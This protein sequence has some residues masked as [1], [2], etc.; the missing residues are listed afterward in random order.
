MSSKYLKKYIFVLLN[1]FSLIAFASAIEPLR[2]ANRMRKD[3][4]FMWETIGITSGNVTCSNGTVVNCK[5]SLGITTHR[6]DTIV[7]C[8]GTNIQKNST[9]PLL[10]WLRREYRKGLNIGGLCTA[11]QILADAGLLKGKKCTIHWENRDS[12]LE[13][14]PDHSLTSS[15][16]VVDGNVFSS[17]GGTASADLMLHLIGKEFG[18]DLA[19]SVADQMIHTSIRTEKDDQRLS[20]PTRIGIRN[21]KLSTVLELMQEALE[22]PYTPS[23]LAV[24]VGIS[25]RQLERLFRRY[26]KRSPKRYYMELRLQK[27]RNLLLQTNMTVINVALACGFSSPSHFSKCYRDYF[28]HTP[29]RERGSADKI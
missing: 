9:K 23:E 19:N 6:D 3:T 1:D 20:I 7:I 18:A 29:Y 13:N 24:E 17:A 12:F 27:S 26:L 28:S 10:S 22:E 15:I 21:Q 25:T 2:L 5:T 14:F 16:Y 4:I 8:G 11:T